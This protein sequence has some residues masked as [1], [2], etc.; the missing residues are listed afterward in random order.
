MHRMMSTV[1][2]NSDAAKGFETHRHAV[3]AWALRIV[4]RHHD[5]LDVA[6]EVYLRWERQ[7]QHET[8]TSPRAWLR[9]VTLNCAVDARR[10][11]SRQPNAMVDPDSHLTFSSAAMPSDDRR[12]LREDVCSA[13]ESLSESQR[14]VLVA[15]VF[16]ELTFAAIAEEMQ[17][18]VP[19][20]KT[21][22]LRAL[23]H[24]REALAVRWLDMEEKE[25]TA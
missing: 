22:Y 16:D 21:H 11:R 14:S 18:A 13:I 6:Q 23:R 9:T 17:L 7:I 25:G 20:V 10:A 24:V 19:T 4:G 12:L 2:Q 5:A 1:A 3:Y 8:P 15:K